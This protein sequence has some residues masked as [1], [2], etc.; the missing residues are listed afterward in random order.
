M[1]AMASIV[2][3]AFHVLLNP[4]KNLLRLVTIAKLSF[5]EVNNLSN[6]TQLVNRVWRQGLDPDQSD[7][8]ACAILGETRL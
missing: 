2:L 6:V 1:K 4:Y 3:N 5:K 8:K 7:S